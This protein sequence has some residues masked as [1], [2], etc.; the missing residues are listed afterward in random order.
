MRRPFLRLAY[1]L[2]QSAQGTSR[3]TPG[4]LH[5]G[6]TTGV[7]ALFASRRCTHS[8]TASLSS[9]WMPSSNSDP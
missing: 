2:R 9:S 5:C 7:G 4:P 6:H 3:Q 8:R 1:P